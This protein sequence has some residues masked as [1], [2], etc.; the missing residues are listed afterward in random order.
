MGARIMKLHLLFLRNPEAVAS[1]P[2]SAVNSGHNTR[3]SNGQECSRE[4][5]R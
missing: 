3:S 2:P 1:G 5:A 4:Q